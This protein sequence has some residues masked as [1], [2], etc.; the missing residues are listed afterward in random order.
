MKGSHLESLQDILCNMKITGLESAPA[1][2]LLLVSPVEA[3]KK[4]F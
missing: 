1:D 4:T 2:F 3:I